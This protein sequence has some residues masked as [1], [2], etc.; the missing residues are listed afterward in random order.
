MFIIE[1]QMMQRSIKRKRNHSE[2]PTPPPQATTFP[3]LLLGIYSRLIRSFTQ[4]GYHYAEHAFFSF[5]LFS[6][7]ASCFSFVELLLVGNCRHAS[8]FMLPTSHSFARL[9]WGR[10]WGTVCMVGRGDLAVLWLE[11]EHGDDVE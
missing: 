1:I 8:S 10:N 6:L 7:F 9:P 2:I 5:S 4:M 11:V 3:D